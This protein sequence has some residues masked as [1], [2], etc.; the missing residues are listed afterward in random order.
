MKKIL[1]CISGS[2]AAYKSLVLIR[3]LKKENFDVKV[4]L[5]E[6]AKQFVT[7]TT[8]E[9][10]SGNKVYDN[11]WE[12]SMDHIFLSRDVDVILVAPATANIIAKIANGICDDLITNVIA[13][14]RKDIPFLIVP[15]MNVEMW[16]NYPNQKNVNQLKK[17]NCIILDPENGMQACNESGCGRMIEPEKIVK[18][19]K[20][21]WYAGDIEK[22]DKEEIKLLITLGGTIEKIDAV[23][24]IA[25]NSS[26][27]MGLAIINAFIDKNVKVIAIIGQTKLQE[28]EWPDG[29]LEKI[30]VRSADEMMKSVLVSLEKYKPDIFISVAAVAD[31][32][33]KVVFNHKIKKKDNENEITLTLV[34]N[35]DILKSV[36]SLENNRPFCVGFAAETSNLLENMKLKLKNKKLDMIVGNNVL[37]AT[38]SDNRVII[39]DKN[40]KII[41][42]GLKNK[43]EIGRIIS[44]VVLE[45]YNSKC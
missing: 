35:C 23:R 39:L 28:C 16:S 1:L 44:D 7:K 12:N 32:K 21:I 9:A 5:S 24:N 4:V 40:E 25:N 11:L 43:E 38:G 31:F 30:F 22:R 15:A 10:L 6:N 41:E 27:K 19:L 34:K 37:D 14:R 29:I 36:S 17:D 13:A 33:P 8:V 2:I 45:S 20:S 42:S 3:L 18:H 26:G